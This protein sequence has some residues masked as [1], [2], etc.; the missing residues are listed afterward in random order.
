MKSYK[1]EATVT[2]HVSLNS[3]TEVFISLKSSWLSA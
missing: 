2:R 1:D 3:M